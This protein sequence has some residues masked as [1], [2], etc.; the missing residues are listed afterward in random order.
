MKNGNND[1]DDDGGDAGEP[2]RSAWKARYL[3]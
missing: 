1:G 2:L 3:F